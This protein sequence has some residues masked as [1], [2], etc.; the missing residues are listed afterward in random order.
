MI[1]TAPTDQLALGALPI[2]TGTGT[3]PVGRIALV[4]VLLAVASAGWWV[5]RRR[6][7]QFR[8]VPTRARRSGESRRSPAEPGREPAG[9][10]ALTSTDLAA[11]LGSRAT[12]VQF[13]AETCASCP[14]ARRVLGALAAAT[15]G[16]VHVDVA[17]EDRM[18]LVRR[19][20]VFRTPT[21][22]LLDASGAV[23]SRTSGPLTADRALA[24]LAE[25]PT[26]AT[27]STHA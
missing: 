9:S 3:G 19:F 14:Q 5:A 10:S 2:L 24:A 21:V 18:D 23:R 6:A 11:E 16:V 22:L 12:F 8:P 27:R 15:P 25:L 4:L 26:P 13:S 1:S 17:S 7:A 20:S